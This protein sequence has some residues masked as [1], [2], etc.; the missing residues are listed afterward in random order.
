[1]LFSVHFK[2]LHLLIQLLE[3]LSSF[4]HSNSVLIVHLITKDILH[5]L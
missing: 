4:S 5:F 3:I 1:M 2:V